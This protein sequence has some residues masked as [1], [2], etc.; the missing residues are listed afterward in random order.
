MPGTW[1]TIALEMLG[2]IPQQKTATNERY[3][4]VKKI[5]K[6]LKKGWS[7]EEVALI[8]NTSLGGAEIPKR[9][10]GVNALGVPY[11]SP[12]YALKVVNRFES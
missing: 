3:V 11:D 12:A 1:E 8:W 6:L 10:K 5:A 7:P 2:Y 4:A 9:V